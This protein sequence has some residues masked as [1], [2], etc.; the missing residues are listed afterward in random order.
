MSSIPAVLFFAI[1]ATGSMRDVPTSGSTGGQS[2]WAV[3]RSVWPQVIASMPASWAAGLMLWSCPGCPS[4]AYQPANYP[5]PM[6]P[7]GPLDGA[8]VT[9]LSNLPAAQVGGYT[10]TECAYNYALQQ[11]Q[12]WAAP[13]AYARSPRYIVLLTDGV[14]TVSNNCQS[15]GNIQAG[16]FPIDET[17]YNGFIATVA[18]G[19]ATTGIKTYVVGVPGS[20]EPQGAPYDPM[21]ML[22][23][24]AAAGGTALPNC[25]PQPGTVN[26]TSGAY[27]TVSP[28]GTYCHY[29]LTAQP[30]FA[31]AFQAATGSIAASLVSC[32]YPVPPL[33]VPYGASTVDVTYTTGATTTPLTQAPQNDCAN[34]GDWHFS[35][36]DANQQPT[37]LELCPTRCAA[38]SATL[39]PTINLTFECPGAGTGGT[40]A[41][42]SG[43]EPAAGTAA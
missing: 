1:D 39:S 9:A 21:Y 34:G 29:D 15:L 43:G 30:S 24:L 16:T 32:R 42:G 18:N 40:A 13:P 37:E 2:K 7:I 27:G 25:T 38:G 12:G 17:Q 5:V 11:V 10:P 4:A 6:V 31:A 23:L 26:N 14:P 8:Q 20:D 33:P 19:T 36:A 3:L 22:S 28:R 35:A 41:G